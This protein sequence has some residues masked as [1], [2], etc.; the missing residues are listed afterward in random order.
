MLTAATVHAYGSWVDTCIS[1]GICTA[2]DTST[3]V[4]EMGEV[5]FPNTAPHRHDE[6]EGI[7]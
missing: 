6:M 7:K 5:L 4:S 1:I 3:V 2:D